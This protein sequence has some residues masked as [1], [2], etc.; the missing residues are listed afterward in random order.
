MLK[1]THS[2]LLTLLIISTLFTNSCKHSDPAPVVVAQR[3]ITLNA[4]NPHSKDTFYVVR[5]QASAILQVIAMAPNQAH[6][7]SRLYI[8]TRSIDNVANPGSYVNYNYTGSGFSQ[9]PK[10][11]YY[12]SV[13]FTNDTTSFVVTVPLRANNLN[14]VTDEFYFV[15]TRDTTFSG[16]L[17]T[18]PAN[19]STI[20][21]GP[22]QFFIVYGKLTEY[23]GLKIYN[24]FTT[25][26]NCDPGYDLWD[27]LSKPYVS[28]SGV[29]D[30]ETISPVSGSLFSG[31]FRSDPG[32][33]TLYVKDSTFPYST[34]TDID[35]I[36]H[37]KK[38]ITSAT[39]T[40]QDSAKIGDIYVLQLRGDTTSYAALKVLYVYPEDGRQGSGHDNEY[41]LFNIKK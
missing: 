21:F 12:Y 30:I 4:V 22:A 7:P 5:T 26:I 14:A 37:Y 41:I 13:P 10:G 28:G 11:Q 6:F 19:L 31:K 39:T 15:Y 34:A 20:L 16:P 23:R 1:I 18:S 35:L 3:T 2:L 36:N 8:Y 17:D 33:G 25:L 29:L 32:N 24:P 40:P 27:V 38:Y 9:D